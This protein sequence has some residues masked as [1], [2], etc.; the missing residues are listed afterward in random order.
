[1]QGGEVTVFAF[2]FPRPRRRLT[3]WVAGACGLWGPVCLICYLLWFALRRG[4]DEFVS[5][6]PGGT[7]V[8]P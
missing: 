4:V 6:P 3:S 5:S 7:S 8:G 2:L 1:M